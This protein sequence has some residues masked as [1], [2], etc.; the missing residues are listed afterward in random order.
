MRQ[1]LWCTLVILTCVFSLY[2]QSVFAPVKG[3]E[4]KYY[5]NSVFNDRYNPRFD[6]VVTIVYEKD[7]LVNNVPVKKLA[8]TE[9]AR[10]EGVPT[11]EYRNLAPLFMMQSNDSVLVWVP[12]SNRFTL[13]F[14]Y[15]NAVGNTTRYNIIQ[16]PDLI[17]SLRL[18]SVTGFNFP[19]NN[20]RFTNYTSKTISNLIDVYKIDSVRILDR[21]GPINSDITHIKS[22]AN[23]SNRA[24][25]RLLC[26]KDTQVGELVLEQTGCNDRLVNAKVSNLEAQNYFYC[27]YD[28]ATLFIHWK[29][30]TNVS[31]KTIEVLDSTGRCIRTLRSDAAEVFFSDL[32]KGVLFVKVIDKTLQ[33]LPLVQKV[34]TF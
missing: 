11:L 34:F 24:E 16:G 30:E 7:T 1:K 29:D 19:N 22:N 4:W 12:E 9:V 23:S 27:T 8:Q 28:G 18:G 31:D 5:Y 3:A 10:R 2:G 26:Y 21:V 20:I 25:Y 33:N 13:A 15:N 17:F 6:G 14:V 32:P